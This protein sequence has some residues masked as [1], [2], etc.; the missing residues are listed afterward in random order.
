MALLLLDKDAGVLV[1]L[2]V[3][4][5][6][7]TL[8]RVWDGTL[9]SSTASWVQ[10]LGPREPGPES[11]SITMRGAAWPWGSYLTSTKPHFFTCELGTSVLTPGVLRGTP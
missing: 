1:K 4:S 7:G 6:V 5:L 11:S 8:L 9:G 2:L 10:V 3:S